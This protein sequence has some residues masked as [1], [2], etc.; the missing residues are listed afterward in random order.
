MIPACIAR[1]TK[2]PVFLQMPFNPHHPFDLPPLPPDWKQEVLF[3][4]ELTR[5]IIKTHRAIGELKGLT[6]AIPKAYPLLMNIPVLQ[7]AV[8]SSA[9]EGIHTTVETLLE[10]QIK[11]EKERDPASKEALRY[12]AALNTGFKSFKSYKSLSTRV[13]LDIHRRIVPGGGN[14]KTQENKIA[15][16]GPV[17]Y[18]PPSPVQINNLMSNWE[19]YVNRQDDKID[20]LIKT[21]VSHY[22]FEAIHPFPDGNG[23]TGRILM[24]LQLVLCELLDWPVLYIS[25]YLIKNRSRYYSLLLEISTS[26][27]WLKFIKFMIKAFHTQ[28]GVTKQV[29]LNIIEAKREMKKILKSKHASLYSQE[30][31][32]HLFSYP[33]TYSKFMGSELNI[34]YQTAGKYLSGLEKVGLLSKK[35]AGTYILYYNLGLLNCLKTKTNE[36]N[37]LDHPVN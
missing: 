29:I 13:I 26:G 22:Q 10:A 35:Q 12:K 33:V 4:P 2:T 15:G 14:F 20:P 23:R 17:L 5:L 7:E 28:A 8:S 31:L 30:L 27:N 21:A 37:P 36:E 11:M 25:G 16:R 19:N 3:E 9:I 32:E 34:T 18:T 1:D 24:V 6:R